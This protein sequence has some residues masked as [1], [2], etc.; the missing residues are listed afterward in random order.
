MPELEC[1]ARTSYLQE[2]RTDGSTRQLN[3]A[4]FD[5]VQR[6]ID[7]IEDDELERNFTR[8]KSQLWIRE[9]P[10]LNVVAKLLEDAICR[11]DAWQQLRKMLTGVN[12][13]VSQKRWPQNHTLVHIDFVP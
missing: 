9:A 2:S 6:V 13:Y 5:F 11:Q 7:A 1:L 3:D 8:L 10:D 12:I 4:M